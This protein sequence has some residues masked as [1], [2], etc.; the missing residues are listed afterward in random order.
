MNA[1]LFLNSPLDKLARGAVSIYSTPT[2]S[3]SFLTIEFKIFESGSQA[4][5]QIFGPERRQGNWDNFVAGVT[6]CSSLAES[7][8][9]FDCLRQANSTEIF[10]GLQAAINEAPEEFGFDPTID[11][12]GGLYPDLPSRL[13]AQ[14]HFAKLPFISGTNLDEGKLLVKSF[15]RYIQKNLT[16]RND[17]HPDNI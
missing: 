5:P 4:T 15:R 8:H 9:T 10:A 17:F 3:H 1:I 11:G 12:A 14:G 16:T 2:I 7:N 13:F 6:S